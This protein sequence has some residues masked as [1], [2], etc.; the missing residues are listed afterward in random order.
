[1]AQHTGNY[2]FKQPWFDVGDVVQGANLEQ[3]TPGTAL[4]GC[5]GKAI[6][7]LGYRMVNVE[8]DPAWTVE[9]CRTDQVSRC[10]H[11]HPEWVEMGLLAECVEN[12]PHVVDSDEIVIDGEL[13]ATNYFYEDT[14]LS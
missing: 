10:S 11:E 2:A 3:I 9:H 8:I 6:T 1:M 4:T 5:A 14:R 13:I 12:C 7:F